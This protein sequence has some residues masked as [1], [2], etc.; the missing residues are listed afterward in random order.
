M[1][2][3]CCLPL[4][5]SN[6]KVDKISFHEFPADL[7]LNSAWLKAISRKD[8]AP[9]DISNSSKVCGYHFKD[10]DFLQFPTR[11][12]LKKGSIPTVFNGYPTYKLIPQK[13]E[14]RVLKR[15]KEGN[16]SLRSKKLRASSPFSDN[17]AANV[18]INLA[19]S[20]YDAAIQSTPDKEFNSIGTQTKTN[21][22]FIANQRVEIKRLRRLLTRR[23]KQIESLQKKL[24]ENSKKLEY[25]EKNIFVQNVDKMQVLYDDG[26]ANKQ[27]EFTLSQLPNFN[28]KT[29]RWSDTIIRECVLLHASSPKGYDAIFLSESC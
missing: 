27:I 14:R 12:C 4:C 8:F 7:E 17:E 2:V 1:P 23:N 25:F 11:R 22:N 16:Q 3:Y 26:L 9:N 24:Q 5:K 18:L 21:C 6:S 20:S 10:S 29:P 15:K 28:K 13:S 19:S